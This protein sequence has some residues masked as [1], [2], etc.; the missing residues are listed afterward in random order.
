MCFSRCLYFTTDYIK[1]N[2]EKLFNCFGQLVQN[3]IENSTFL[4]N[5]YKNKHIEVDQT[6]SIYVG[7]AFLCFETKIID[8]KSKKKSKLS[9]NL[10]MR[11][12]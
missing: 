11:L 10:R 3:L 12:S 6:G 2:I 9:W 8:Q 1:Y 7:T 4:Q 5:R